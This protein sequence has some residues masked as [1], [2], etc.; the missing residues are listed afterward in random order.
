[1]QKRATAFHNPDDTYFYQREELLSFLKSLAA[2]HEP[3]VVH[4]DILL[5]PDDIYRLLEKIRNRH[6]F[7]RKERHALSEAGFNLNQ[8]YPGL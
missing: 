3:L 6:H 5:R 2:R 7:S 8:I 1:L 4:E